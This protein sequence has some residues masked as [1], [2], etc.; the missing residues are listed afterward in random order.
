[1][2]GL[3]F[4]III[5]VSSIMDRFQQL[6]FYKCETAVMSSL[7]I[8][9]D[10]FVLDFLMYILISII[11]CVTGLMY[12]SVAFHGGVREIQDCLHFRVTPNK[13]KKLRLNRNT[14]IFVCVL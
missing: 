12:F 1:M 9:S 14:M 11:V 3:L 6:L 5:I 4:S 7:M 13:K 10:L 8:I 2:L